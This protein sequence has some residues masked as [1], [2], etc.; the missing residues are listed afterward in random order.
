MCRRHHC[1]LPFSSGI[2]HSLMQ[3]FSKRVVHL[4]EM[5]R[6][7]E[8][9]MA[10]PICIWISEFQT[11]LNHIAGPMLLTEE[12]TCF[13]AATLAAEKLLEALRL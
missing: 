5:S 9:Q 8:R 11:E 1:F 10:T 13:A 7:T 12:E 6:C 2:I 3:C 4:F